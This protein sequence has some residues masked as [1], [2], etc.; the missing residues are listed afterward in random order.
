[1]ARMQLLIEITDAGE[2]SVTGPITEKLLCYG[3]L[4]AAKDAIR[5]AGEQA[6]TERRIVP[7]AVVAMP[8]GRM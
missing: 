5:N 3:L 1:M 7:A 4:E 8:K 6:V 2:V